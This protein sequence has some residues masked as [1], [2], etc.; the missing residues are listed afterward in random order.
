MKIL[1]LYTIQYTRIKEELPI[2][3]IMNIL[4]KMKGPIILNSVTE[5]V[6]KVKS[7]FEGPL[8]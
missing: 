8:H 3:E 1:S 4:K 6:I 2:L 5:E 7:N